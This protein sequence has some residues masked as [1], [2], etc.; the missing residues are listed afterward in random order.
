M[1]YLQLLITRRAF[2]L[3]VAYFVSMNESVLF[4]LSNEKLKWFDGFV[5]EDVSEVNDGNLWININK[6]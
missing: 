3:E 4:D 5:F 6:S 2:L 1:V